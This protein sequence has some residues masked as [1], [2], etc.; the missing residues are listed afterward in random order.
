MAA[1]KAGAAKN[2]SGR[3]SASGK[4][5]ARTAVKPADT[6]NQIAA[7]IAKLAPDNAALT[8]A[9]R[10]ALRQR[11]PTAFELGYDNYNFL[12]FGFCSTPKPSS[13]MVSLAVAAN[14]AAL[15]FYHGADLPNPD[16]VLLGEGK[17]NRF[18]RLPCAETL[19]EPAV[20]RA[21]TA[22]VAF[23]KPPLAKAGSGATVVQSISAKQ[24]PRKRIGE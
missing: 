23:T 10:A 5:S 11:F 9:C 1:K 13:C 3:Q 12:V 6:E 7:F 21:I 17:Q 16:G 14:G 15:S 19:S 24:R 20:E 22:A 2:I 8:R 18:V 4:A